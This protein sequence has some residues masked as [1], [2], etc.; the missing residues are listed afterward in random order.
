MTKFFMVNIFLTLLGGAAAGLIVGVKTANVFDPLWIRKGFGVFLILSG[1]L[2]L[3]D[4]I[5]KSCK[6]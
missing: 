1:G 3:F 5:K 4:T 2:G 6:N